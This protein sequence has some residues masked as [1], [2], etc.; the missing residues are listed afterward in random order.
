MRGDV[1]HSH[2]LS[3]AHG[4]NVYARDHDDLLRSHKLFHAHGGNA[5]ARDHDDLLLSHKL[6]HAHGGN[7]YA[8]DDV[9]HSHSVH[10]SLCQQILSAL[11]LCL[12]LFFPLFSCVS[13]S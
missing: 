4:G 5:Y 7:V 10:E 13:T 3:H 2:K 9:P 12:F 8:H 11:S 1:L 6:S